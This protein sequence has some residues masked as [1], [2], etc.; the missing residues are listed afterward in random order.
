MP[1]RDGRPELPGPGVRSALV[2]LIEDRRADG[3]GAVRYIQC[4]VCAGPTPHAAEVQIF[5]ATVRDPVFVAAPP[6]VVCGVCW[7]L[8]PRVVNDEPPLD[9]EFTCTRRRLPK[10][11]LD[12]L[13]PDRLP[14]AR[15]RLDRLK[16][17]R[18]PLDRL[19][20]RL[21]QPPLRPLG[22]VLQATPKPSL[23]WPG[24]CA[25]V[26]LVPATAPT[27]ICPR[28]TTPQPGPAAT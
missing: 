15:L 28:C 1:D 16:L 27:V 4:D 11:P 24:T 7:S 22:R 5:S 12:R 2:A 21:P 25:H 17:Q 10:L 20:A 23:R 13:R 3:P 9:T 26:F 6:E 8:H 19:A 14:L 18:L